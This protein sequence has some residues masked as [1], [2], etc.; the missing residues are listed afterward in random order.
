M[1]R[2]IIWFLL[3]LLLCSDSSF[4]GDRWD[5]YVTN[6]WNQFK[7]K[8]NFNT[9]LYTG[10]WLSGMYALSHYDEDINSSVKSLYKGKFKTYIDIVDH[11][12]N[13]PYSIPA[14]AGIAGL[15]LVGNDRKL[16]DAAFTSLEAACANALIIG[17]SKLMFGRNRPDAKKG[18]HDF[19][20]FS[21]N[22]ASFPSG[23]ASTAFALITPWVYYYPG[24]LTYAL[25]VI[26]ASTALARVILDRHWATDVLTGSLIGILIGYNLARWHKRLAVDK[27]YYGNSDSDANLSVSFAIPF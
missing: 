25:L 11:L 22:Q 10:T 7:Q 18:A 21:F 15:T 19:S 20:P 5:S 23:H 26:P 16:H 14:M 17:I 12:G 6:D 13:A 4:S 3:I 27:N 1:T 24:P 8:L 2:R 9:L